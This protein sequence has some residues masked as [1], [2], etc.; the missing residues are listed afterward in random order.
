MFSCLSD[1]LQWPVTGL[2][3]PF[4]L[5]VVSAAAAPATCVRSRRRC[6]LPGGSPSLCGEETGVCITHQRPVWEG[7]GGGHHGSHRWKGAL[8]T[9][10]SLRHCARLGRGWRVTHL[11]HCSVQMDSSR[12]HI[13]ALGKGVTVCVTVWQTPMDI[14][15]HIHMTL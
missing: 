2:A 5:P 14:S 3:S 10:I 11:R 13:T 1:L 12:M 4:R 8:V 6:V 15:G 7:R 9:C